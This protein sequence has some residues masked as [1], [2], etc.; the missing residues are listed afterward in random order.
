MT[1]QLEER[2]E[3]AAQNQSLFREVNERMETLGRGRSFVQ[4]VCECADLACAEEL[5]LTLEEYEHV[6]ASP[7]TFVV[8]PGHELPD[9]E[10]TVETSTRFVVVRKRG[11]AEAIAAERDP[12]DRVG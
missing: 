12:R 9:V 7:A 3:R 6:R 10:S 8:R 11:V 5:S 1:E 2:Q 4:F